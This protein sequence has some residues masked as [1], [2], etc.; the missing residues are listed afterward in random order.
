MSNKIIRK[1]IMGDTP[2]I[3]DTI[4]YNPPKWKGLI[5]TK[6]IGFSEV[7]LPIVEYKPYSWLKGN[8]SPKTGFIIA[9]RGN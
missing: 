8:Q 7:G 6:V 9:K 4:A 2:N 3:G 1:D 5:T